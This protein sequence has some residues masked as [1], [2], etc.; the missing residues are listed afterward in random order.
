MSQRKI[1][2]V[3]ALF[4]LALSVAG[5]GWGYRG[6]QRGSWEYTSS[7]YLVSGLYLSMQGP[8]EV[9]PG[10]HLANQEDGLLWLSAYEATM[11][12]E[13]AERT[14]GQDFMCH[15][16]LFLDSSVR[17]YRALLG[18]RPYGSPR[19]FTLAQG[20]YR[21]EFP[22]GFAIPFPARQG[23][24]L[25]SQVLNLM[26]EHTGTVVRHRI[27]AEFTPD[28]ALWRKPKPLFLVEATGRVLVGEP[29]AQ[30]G[31]LA[32]KATGRTRT[33]Q[34]GREWAGHWQ[35]PPGQHLY[36]TEVTGELGL[37]FDTE[38]HYVTSHLHPYARWQELRDL[39]EG[40][41]V[42]YRVEP[43]WSAD[44]RS[45]REIPYASSVEGIPLYANHHYELATLYDNTSRA[46]ITAMSIL[47]L[48][49]LDKEFHSYDPSAVPAKS[50]KPAPPPA[51]DE[52]CAPAI[53]P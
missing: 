21:L 10:I 27:R 26:P 52:M 12:D 38:A 47:F 6:N 40:G 14:L 41:K 17:D 37:P 34:E 11:V 45:L 5:L 8:G 48:Y 43:R 1:A 49:C 53:T 33:D 36:T 16:S 23:L 9:K 46:P 2:W 42:V 30:A 7:P 50:S 25:Q 4:F 18:T 31:K 44:G 22:P 32:I 20:A 35:V 39:T 15:N 29:N 13:A 28:S 24:Q 19:I 3:L 51:V